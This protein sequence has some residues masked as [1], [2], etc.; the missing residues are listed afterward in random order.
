MNFRLEYGNYE[1]KELLAQCIQLAKE[2]RDEEALGILDQLLSYDQWLLS[3]EK[4]S[5]TNSYLEG[6]IS[7]LPTY[8]YDDN[9]NTYDTSKKQRTPSW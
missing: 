3:K 4:S 7:F 2:G 5:L 1:T 9:S 6:K 8:K